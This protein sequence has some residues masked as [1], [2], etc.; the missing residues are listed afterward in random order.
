MSNE[1]I[2]REVK[3]NLFFSSEEM[4]IKTAVKTELLTDW[5]TK[6]EVHVSYIEL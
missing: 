5:M 2:F 6:C 4:A 1:N 3:I